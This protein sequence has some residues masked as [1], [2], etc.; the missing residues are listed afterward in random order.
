MKR[1]FLICLFVLS[2]AALAH[3]QVTITSADMFNQVGLYY[4]AYANDYDPLDTTGGTAYSVPSTLIGTVG[5]NQFWDFST[6][7][8]NKIFRYDYISPTGLVQAADF[9]NAKIV[10]QQTDETTSEQQW[11]FFEIIPGSGRRVYGF[12]ADNPEFTPPSTVFDQPV[13]DFPDPIP[14]G[15]KWTAS[16]TYQ[17]SLTFSDFVVPAEVTQS[18][19]FTADASGTI[20]LPDQLGT[21]GQGLRISEEETISV[22]ADL[23]EGLQNVDTEYAHNYYWLMPNKGIVAQL[24]STQSSS[25][26]PANFTRA[27]AFLRMF[28]TNKKG[29]STGGGCVDPQAVTDLRIRVSN[30]VILLSWSKAQCANQYTVEYTVDPGDSSSWKAL[31]P[32]TAGTFW[33]G[34]SLATGPTRF[35]RVVSLK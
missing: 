16:E 12:Y 9:P 10:E 34:E 23:G 21:F 29:T 13:V 30:G 35:Y 24:N 8:T 19:D 14:Y 28:E 27:T 26:P 7:P 18:S 1:T 33:Q 6:G 2:G 20:V 3:G 4:R 31:G 25:P 5:T 15:W 22:S 11:L 32:P 17:T